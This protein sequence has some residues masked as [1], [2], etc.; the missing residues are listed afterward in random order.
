MK[1]KLSPVR[2]DTKPLQATIKNK[3]VITING[4]DYDFSQLKAG[5]TL[6]VSALGES[7]PFVSGVE[8]DMN[9]ELHFTLRLPHGQ[10]A[11]QETR[12]PAAYDTPISIESGELPVPPYD[13]LGKEALYA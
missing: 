1:I 2:A 7:S 12:F 13:E 10:F 8:R 6:P 9:G 4:I 3:D 11:P 5:E